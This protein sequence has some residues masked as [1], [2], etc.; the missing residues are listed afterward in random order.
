MSRKSIAIFLFLLAPVFV[1]GVAPASGQV[2][3]TE[4][5]VNAA[6]FRPG[7][8][9]QSIASLFGTELSTEIC[10][11]SATPLPA[12]MCG[13]S[14]I[15]RDSLGNWAPAPLFY[16]SPGQINFQ[17]PISLGWLEICVNESCESVF[18]DLQAPAIFEYQRE[19]GVL[20]PII[21]HAD[22]SLVTPESPAAQGEILILYATGMGVGGF[23]TLFFPRDGEP[24]PLDRLVEFD[25]FSRIII[26]REQFVPVLFAGL[27]PGFVG[28]A[29]FNFKLEHQMQEFM[30]DT[31]RFPSGPN[32][33]RIDD[34]GK[35]KTVFLYVE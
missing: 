30:Q 13:V 27:A 22:G 24:A 18:V 28:L 26:V 4:G 11:A 23:R 15:F 34:L 29:Q 5:I 3:T 17:V 16:V 35:S 25:F 10:A 31:F 6:N 1:L 9:A 7:I 14:V 2:F 12:T 20:D 33:L 32:A 21:T 19:P 8:A